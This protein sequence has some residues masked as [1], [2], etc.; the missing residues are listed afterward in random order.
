MEKRAAYTAEAEPQLLQQAAL[1]SREAYAALYQHYLPK[2]YKYLCEI[3]RSKE[4]TEEILQD[5]FLKLWENKEELVK[6]KALNGYLF[7]MAR[8]K[9]MNRYDHQKVAQKAVNYFGATAADSGSTSE[10]HYIYK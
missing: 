7:R 4:D 6:V 3:I 10:D 8:N 9:L 2:L 1:G 5:V